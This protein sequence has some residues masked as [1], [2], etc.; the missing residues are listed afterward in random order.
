MRYGNV[1][2]ESQSAK[3]TQHISPGHHS[4]HPTGWLTVTTLCCAVDLVI[5]FSLSLQ[6]R[7]RARVR[8]GVR[9][10][11]RLK[12]RVSIRVKYKLRV[13]IPLSV[14]TRVRTHSRWVCTYG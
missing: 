5:E 7:V 1:D 9:V 12:L 4:D 6:A 14:R 2:A 3:K 8:I 11:V 13:R 10:R